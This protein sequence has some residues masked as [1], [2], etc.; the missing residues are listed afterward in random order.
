MCESDF[1]L[2]FARPTWQKVIT[3]QFSSRLSEFLGKPQAGSRLSGTTRLPCNRNVKIVWNKYTKRVNM[4]KRVES[5]RLAGTTRPCNRPLS[6]NFLLAIASTLYMATKSSL[7]ILILTVKNG[8]EH[9][10]KLVLNTSNV[11][12]HKLYYN[13]SNSFWKTR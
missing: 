12:L 5:T 10:Q 4:A 9:A 7:I 8:L 2:R 11:F 13:I 6:R 1:L 3:W